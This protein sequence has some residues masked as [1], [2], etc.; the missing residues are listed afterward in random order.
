MAVIKV[1]PHLLTPPWEEVVEEFLLTKKAEGRSPL[2]LRD[3]TRHLK[4]FFRK[5]PDAWPDYH[6][7]KA[8]IRE[9]FAALASKSPTAYNLP[10]AYLKHFFGWCVSEGYLVGNPLEG[11]PKR[12]DEGRPRSVDEET[13][14]ALLSLP[15]RNSYTGIRDYALIL[16]QVDTGIRPGEALQLTPSCFNLRNLEVTIPSSVAKTRQARVV[17][18]SPQ[19][20]KAIKRLLAVRPAA[21]KEDVPVFASQ[22]G[23]AMLE[24]SWAHRLRRYGQ[25]LGVRVNP[26]SLR[27]TAAI[28]SLRNGGSAFFVQKQLGHASLA[29]TKRYVHLVEADLHR[30]HE[31]CSPVASILPERQRAKRK[32]NSRA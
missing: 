19:T 27:H 20:A 5:H 31:V 17:V 10:R 1:S 24:T 29:M 16:L 18:I 13:I 3:Y 32:V 23:K 21:W 28:M 8:A 22:D 7:L 2:T 11:V 12:K 6:K 14:K 25:K 9:Y 26:Y 30:E 15:D 4:T